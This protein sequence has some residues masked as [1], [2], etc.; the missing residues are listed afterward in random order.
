MNRPFVLLLAAFAMACGTDP[1]ADISG[2]VAGSKFSPQAF[3]WGGPFIVFT[4]KAYEC[5]DMYWVKRG[6]NYETGGEVPVEEDLTAL[7]FTYEDPEV[8]TGDLSLE[9]DAP[10]DARMLVVKNG[11]LTVYRGETG[12]LDVTEIGEEEDAVGS[13]NVGFD[14]GE[15]TGDFQVEWC[16]NV[17]SKY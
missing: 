12:N 7:L 3:F 9:G 1:Y 17:T 11:A 6:P 15:L 13:F 2:S 4:D 8:V 10:V 16:T 14:E 5:M